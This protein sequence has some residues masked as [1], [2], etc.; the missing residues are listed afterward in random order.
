MR[1]NR[2]LL[3]AIFIPAAYVMLVVLL[4]YM[5]HQASLLSHGQEH[6]T[7]AI[8]MI[9]GIIPFAFFML[10]IFRGIQGHIL[11]QNDELSLRNTELAALMKVGQAVEE[12]SDLDTM[13][14][15]AVH[16]KVT[17]A[18]GSCVPGTGLAI[19]GAA[20]VTVIWSVFVSV[21]ALPPGPVTVRLTV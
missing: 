16:S 11:R 14:P 21:S 12:S 7:L 9:A 6:L 18:P 10:R 1:L 13:L 20:V 8:S 5:P 2:L 4:S 19:V 17:L 15:V 3:I